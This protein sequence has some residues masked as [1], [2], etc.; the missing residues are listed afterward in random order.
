MTREELI[1]EAVRRTARDWFEQG[2]L[3]DL[4]RIEHAADWFPLIFGSFSH[5]ARR[6]FRQLRAAQPRDSH[7]RFAR[8]ACRTA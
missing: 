8:K 2:S 4:R 1:D 7:G 5:T 3:F 6:H